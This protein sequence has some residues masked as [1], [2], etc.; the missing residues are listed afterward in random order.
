MQS[1]NFDSQNFTSIYKIPKTT[2]KTHVEIAEA[3]EPLYRKNKDVPFYC[4]SGDCPV[5]ASVASIIDEDMKAKHLSYDW[6]VDNAKNFNIN[7]PDPRKIDVWVVTGKEDIS[8]I[9]NYLDS[10]DKICKPG[11]WNSLKRRLFGFERNYNI[12]EH[13]DIY[14]DI[15]EMRKKLIDQ[16]HDLIKNDSIIEAKDTNDFFIKLVE[17]EL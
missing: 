2:V 3:I 6:I 9:D 5:D 12:P 15:L 8:R 4:F 17:K 10:A 1:L 14:S 7:L 11:F 16:F 13:L